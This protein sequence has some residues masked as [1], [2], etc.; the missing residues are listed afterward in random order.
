MTIP[1]PDELL[2]AFDQ[3]RGN[4]DEAQRHGYTPQTLRYLWAQWLAQSTVGREVAE[5][6]ATRAIA[7]VESNQ[8]LREREAEEREAKEAVREEQER[9]R[10]EPGTQVTLRHPRT[11]VDGQCGTVQAMSWQGNQLMAEVLVDPLP[12]G[13]P[14]QG[15]PVRIRRS[16]FRP[17]SL[18]V[19]ADQLAVKQ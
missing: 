15:R 19:A 1:I 4:P 7:E 13:H 11:Q 10:L 3:G 18:R 14:E 9:W 12:P 8:L 2:A 16:G 6:L 17:F 5:E